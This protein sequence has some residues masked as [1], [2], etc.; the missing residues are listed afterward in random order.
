MIS[1]KY[2]VCD[3]LRGQWP[4]CLPFPSWR[5]LPPSILPSRLP[6]HRAGQASVSVR[7]F[8]T[9]E[10]VPAGCWAAV[11]SSSPPGPPTLNFHPCPHPSLGWASGAAPW[12]ARA[13]HPA[14][15]PALLCGQSQEGRPRHLEGVGLCRGSGGTV[16][17]ARD[18]FRGV[19][20]MFLISFKIRRKSK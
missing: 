6:W 2:G 15:G 11:V 4:L 3:R 8:T 17:T 20:K 14:V 5:N 1:R 7:C 13:L 19:T 9:W 10:E 18:T 12:R 16:L